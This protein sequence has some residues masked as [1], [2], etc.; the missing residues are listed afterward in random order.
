[1]S[2]KILTVDREKVLDILCKS[3]YDREGIRQTLIWR[4]LY[5]V[6]QS[7]A[8]ENDRLRT[9]VKQL[10]AKCADQAKDIESYEKFVENLR[11]DLEDVPIYETEDSYGFD[12]KR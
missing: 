1:M 7:L 11:E 10:S 12:S 2:D 4:D 9:S 3:G 6:L 5:T 8:E